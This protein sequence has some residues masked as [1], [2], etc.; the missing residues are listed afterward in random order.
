MLS[1]NSTVG[2]VP[3]KTGDFFPYVNGDPNNNTHCSWTG[4]FVTNPYSKRLI[5]SFGEYIRGMKNLLALYCLQGNKQ[6]DISVDEMTSQADYYSW[7]IGLNTHHDT[8]TGTSRMVA[9][10]DYVSKIKDNFEKANST[11]YLFVN[12]FF[13]INQFHTGLAQ[14]LI[15]PFD[16]TVRLETDHGQNY[17]TYFVL[18]QGGS[19][20]KLLRFSTDAS[21]PMVKVNTTER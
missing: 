5:R 4:Y 2:D 11:F 21:W 7:L 17:S 13:D 19:N 16:E 10:L 18:S 1:D 8:I 15:A 20:S 6:D 14:Q 9:V 3:E 12:T